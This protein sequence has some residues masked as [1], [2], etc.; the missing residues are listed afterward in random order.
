V[1]VEKENFMNC[2]SFEL[3]DAVLLILLKCWHFSVIS[4]R[5]LQVVFL[6][7]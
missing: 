5:L 4:V 3:W 2:D 1:E 6:L 7:G